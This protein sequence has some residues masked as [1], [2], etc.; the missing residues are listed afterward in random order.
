[1]LITRRGTGHLVVDLRDASAMRDRL[2]MPDTFI[3]DG[4]FGSRAAY[5]HGT[6]ELRCIVVPDDYDGPAP[7]YP[8][9]EVGRITLGAEPSAGQMTSGTWP[10]AE[11]GAETATT[12][13]WRPAISESFGGQPS[14]VAHGGGVGA[15]SPPS[16]VADLDIAATMAAWDSV[17]DPHT[18]VAVL[19]SASDTSPAV[20]SLAQYSPA[21]PIPAPL[22]PVFIPGTL[23]KF[24]ESAIHA[25]QAILEAIGDILHSEQ[26]DDKPKASPTANAPP[27]PIPDR[28]GTPAEIPRGLPP[29]GVMPPVENP[30]QLT[31]GPA[32]RPSE[33]AKGGQSLWDHSGGEWRYFP[34]DTYHDPHWDYNAHSTPNSP[35][36]NVPINDSSPVKP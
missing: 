35:W 18:T 34:G 15:G 26:S 13:L 30:D 29:T 10:T 6:L 21:S 36:R 27:P 16:A 9:I 11:R 25:G 17:S 7:G 14:T 32:S 20:R 3:P 33:A 8:W 22:P 12:S 5:G 23:E 1:M 24:V 2:E 4:S 31:T 28:S 19:N